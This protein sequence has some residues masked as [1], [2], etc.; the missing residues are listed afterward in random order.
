MGLF[1]GA[2]SAR[3]LV[4]DTLDAVKNAY[5]DFD[6]AKY[7]QDGDGEIDRLWIIHA[8]LGEEDSTTLLN[9]T[10]TEK[11]GSG[12][13]HRACPLLRGCARGFRQVRIS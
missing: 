5:P 12:P 8:G 3:T 2:G 13:I 11:A 10:I 9:R 4:R 7:D 6:W 1:P